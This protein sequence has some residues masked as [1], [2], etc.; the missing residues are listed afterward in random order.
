MLLQNK[1]KLL[2]ELDNYSV[3]I[4]SNHIVLK[5]ALYRRL[6][7]IHVWSWIQVNL[8]IFYLTCPHEINLLNEKELD[9]NKQTNKNKNY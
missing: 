2:F 1:V 4:C 3:I 8:L 9:V 5:K 7:L 6:K